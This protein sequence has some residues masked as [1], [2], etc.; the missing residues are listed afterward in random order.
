MGA[1]SV[2][3]P[4][5]EDGD[6]PPR[7]CAKCNNASVLK[8]KSRTWFEAFCIPLF[9]FTNSHIYRCSICGWEVKQNAGFE[10]PI[11]GRQP[12]YQPGYAPN[13]NHGYPPNQ[14]MQYK[15]H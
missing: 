15:A 6:N 5:Q 4:N 7:I 1:Y 3:P 11:A 8:C 14:G 10:P 9:P 2:V 13:P 12:Q